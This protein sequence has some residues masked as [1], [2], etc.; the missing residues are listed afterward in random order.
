MDRQSA[1]ILTLIIFIIFGLLTY[2]GAQITLWS[3][4]IFSL[5]VS[6]ILLYLFY[7]LSQLTTDQPDLSLFFYAAFEIIA[8]VFLA[9]YITQKTLCDVKT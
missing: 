9:I 6:L 7:P 8:I 3:S 1:L 5:F 4:F 2:Y